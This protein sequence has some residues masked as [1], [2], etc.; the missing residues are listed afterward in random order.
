MIK[1]VQISLAIVHYFGIFFSKNDRE[2]ELEVLHTISPV[3]STKW[4]TTF[5]CIFHFSLKDF[6]FFFSQMPDAFGVCG[7]MCKVKKDKNLFWG[8]SQNAR[9]KVKLL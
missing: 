3:K 9:T 8:D 7:T 6:E 4:V 2:I 5:S 1:E